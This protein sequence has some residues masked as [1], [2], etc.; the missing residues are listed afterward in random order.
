[1]DYRLNEVGNGGILMKKLFVILWLI[2]LFLSISAVE[3]LGKDSRQ[4]IQVLGF[5][6]KLLETFKMS[7]ETMDNMAVFIDDTWRIEV[8]R[9]PIGKELSKAAYINYSK[10]FLCNT[11]DHQKQQEKT[12]VINGFEIHLLQW[13]RTPLLY[14][15]KDYP[16]YVCADIDC[17]NVVGTIL[18]KSTVP[19]DKTHDYLAVLKSFNVLKPSYNRTWQRSA[20]PLLKNNDVKTIAQAYWNEETKNIYQHYFGED[21]ALTWGIFEP[22]APYDFTGLH[23]LEEKVAYQFPFIVQYSHFSKDATRALIGDDLLS[24]RNEGKIVE[25]S[26]QTTDNDGNMV[27]DILNGQYDEFLQTYIAEIKRAQ[28]TVLMRFCNEMNGDWCAYSGYHTSRDPEVF[29][30]LYYYVYRLFEEADALAYTIWVWN[31]NEKSFP[32]FVWNQAQRYYPGDDY[33]DV[34]GLTGYNT[35]NYYQ[36]EQWREFTAIYDTLYENALIYQKPLMITEFACS[37]YG[38]DKEVWVEKMFEII[39]QYEQIKVAIWWSS[40]DWD[41]KGNVARAYWLDET[42]ELI[43][44]FRENLQ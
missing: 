36:G 21:S 12:I 31:P 20:E 42:E 26:L 19:F 3:L 39:G 37:S 41:N 9:Q 4:L 44:I 6:F 10:G 40:C 32:D 28:T 22:S 7:A 16:Y 17:G 1:M 8:Y 18:F 23:I 27:Y 38:G 33:V 35:G 29:K 43:D 11:I 15:Q 25:L 30:E 14:V 24:A 13:S 5:E 34:I 2:I